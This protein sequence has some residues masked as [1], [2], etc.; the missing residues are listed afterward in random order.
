MW[1]SGMAPLSHE[2]NRILVVNV[3]TASRNDNLGENFSRNS[4]FESCLLSVFVLFQI[5][6][7]T[8]QFNL[9]LRNSRRGFMFKY[10]ITLKEELS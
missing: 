7:K 9:Y 6:R 10:V 8:I 4:S 5:K 3:N 2:A 1:Q